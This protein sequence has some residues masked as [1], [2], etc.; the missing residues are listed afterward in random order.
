MRSVRAGVKCEIS[1]AFTRGGRN[2]WAKMTELDD[3]ALSLLWSSR[4]TLGLLLVGHCRHQGDGGIDGGWSTRSSSQ[5]EWDGH[6]IIYTQYYDDF[7][8]KYLS[9][10]ASRPYFKRQSLQETPSGIIQT[11]FLIMLDWYIMSPSWA[12]VGSSGPL[13]LGVTGAAVLIQRAP[14]AVAAVI[15]AIQS[16]RP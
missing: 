6:I 10:L 15:P 2:T 5:W 16:T 1:W 4:P 13:V 9:T 11:I 7:D 12:E 3:I 14:K 8:E